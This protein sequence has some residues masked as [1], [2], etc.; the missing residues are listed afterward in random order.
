MTVK[1]KRKLRECVFYTSCSKEEIC[2][3]ALPGVDVDKGRIIRQ[4]VAVPVTA[5]F[6]KADVIAALQQIINK[7]LVSFKVFGKSV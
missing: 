2:D 4:T 1:I 6:R 5:V 7:F 3:V